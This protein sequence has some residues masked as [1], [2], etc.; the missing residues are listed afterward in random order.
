MFTQLKNLFPTE[1]TFIKRTNTS[2]SVTLDG[3]DFISGLET[4]GLDKESC[5]LKCIEYSWC[6]GTRIGKKA[7]LGCRLLTDQ[8]PEKILD[9]LEWFWQAGGSWAEPILWKNGSAR[10]YECYEKI[11]AGVFIKRFENWFLRK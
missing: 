11:R 4:N 1:Y 5:Q 2:C 9:G 10:G 8:E 7:T 6:K 3:S